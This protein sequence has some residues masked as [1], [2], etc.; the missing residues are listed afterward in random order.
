MNRLSLF[1]NILPYRTHALEV[2][3]RHTLYVEECGRPDGLPVVFLHGGPGSGCEAWHRRF[4]DPAIYRIVLF[5]Q[6]G[7]GRST[8]HAELTDNTTAHLVADIERIREYLEIDR[9]VLFGGSWGATLGLAYAEAH[10]E[11]VRG[12]VLRGIF[13]CRAQDIAWF[14]QSGAG[15]LFPDYWQDFLAPIPAA[16]RGDLVG[17]YRRRLVGEDEVARMA[18]ARAWSLWEGRTATLY[19]NVTVEE[20]FAD[21]HV[22]LALARI[23]NHY[24]VHQGFLE[25]DQL[26]AQAGRLAGTPGVI[27][28]GR[29]DV[30]CPVDQ[31]WALS[32]AWS[33]SQLEIVPDAGHSAAEPG[34]VDA[35]IRA[36]NGLAARLA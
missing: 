4:F 11:R 17:A 33:G 25:P 10:P 23:E 28:H 21:P 26:L 27:V 2:D 34:I 8:P 18:A 29:Y 15:R 5:D 19:P 22:A 30:I 12:A 1:P 20:H 13:L 24:F 3:D 6:R 31:A 36:T 9:W 14:Y 16:E 7:S 35:L 32:Q